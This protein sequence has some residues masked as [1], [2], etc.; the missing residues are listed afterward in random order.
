MSPSLEQLIYL[1]YLHHHALTSS[2]S[3]NPTPQTNIS[4]KPHHL[5]L[6]TIPQTDRETYSQFPHPLP[7]PTETSPLLPSSYPHI[8]AS[9]PLKYFSFSPL[10][11]P[12]PSHHPPSLPACQPFSARRLLK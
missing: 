10:P 4:P 9:P 5:P 12:I 11:F 2:L 1:P 3:S 8:L 6:P 7:P